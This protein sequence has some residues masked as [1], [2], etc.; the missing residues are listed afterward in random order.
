MSWTV[1][2]EAAGFQRVPLS[3]TG[4][5]HFEA[6]GSLNDRSVRI[7]IDSG[8]ANTV[9]NLS[10]VLELGLRVELLVRRGAG[11]R[12]GGLDL[13]KVDGGKLRL[14]NVEPQLLE[15]RAMDLTQVNAALSEKGVSP[16]DVILGVDV[17]DAHAAVSD[18][19]SSS[20]F[21]RGASRVGYRYDV[22][23]SRSIVIRPG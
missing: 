16:V 9:A 19:G 7:L 23:G 1:F 18:Y 12:E 2:L 14:G 22:R 15:L 17:F 3:R 6:A 10:R 5:G 4:V 21:L 20:L 13:F 11:I 8:A